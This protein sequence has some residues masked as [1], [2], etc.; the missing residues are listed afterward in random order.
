MLHLVFNESA[1]PV[2]QAAMELDESL[3]AEII[4]IED[5]YSLG[6]IENI[7]T[8]E[9]RE[10]RKEWWRNFSKT[11]VADKDN[12]DINDSQ[13]I[14]QLVGRLRRE[15]EE[16]VWVWAAQNSRDVCGYYWVLNY[17]KEFQGRIFILYLNNLP[18]INEKG[19]IFYPDQLSEILPSEFLKAK[20]L[21]RE[22]TPSEFEVD[23]DEWTKLVNENAA[24][25]LLEGGKKIK[26]VGEDFFDAE[27]KKIITADW[28]KAGKVLQQFLTKNHPKIA[29]AFLLYRLKSLAVSGEYDVQG[30]TESRKDFEIKKAV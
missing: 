24:V 3:Q 13:T 19:S 15:A 11:A 9:G 12:E 20:K 27:L 18:F 4:L 16:I 28:Q 21:A 5:D 1:V 2:L 26:S 25:R 6:E 23:P 17:L 7:Y 8:G 14:A 29:E 30:K 10:A 22:I